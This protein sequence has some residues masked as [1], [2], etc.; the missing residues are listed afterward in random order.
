MR[1]RDKLKNIVRANIL[2]EQRYL[3]SKGLLREDAVDT[4]QQI[5]QEPIGSFAPKFKGIASD[6]KVQAVLKAGLKDGD[7]N[8]EKT[9]LSQI[10]A[11]ATQL[12]PTQNVIGTN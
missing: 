8:D 7:E 5:M 11:V 9:N 10:V 2:A 1:R 6:P 12:R 4:L 3:K